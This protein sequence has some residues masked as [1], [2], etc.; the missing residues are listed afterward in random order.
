[1]E[2][3]DSQKDPGLRRRKE[4]HTPPSDGTQ[5]SSLKIHRWKIILGVLMLGSLTLKLVVT[6][7]ILSGSQCNHTLKEPEGL[8]K[9]QTSKISTFVEEKVPERGLCTPF[10][11]FSY[12]NVILDRDSASSGLIIYPD[13]KSVKLDSLPQN[14]PRFQDIY[15]ARA[16]VRGHEGF[17]SG[18]HWW[19]VWVMAG[20][21]WSLGLVRESVYSSN[22]VPDLNCMPWLIGNCVGDCPYPSLFHPA[23]KV[24]NIKVFLDYAKGLVVFYVDNNL[25]TTVLTTSFSDEKIYPVFC[26]GVG[27]HLQ[28]SYAGQ[29]FYWLGTIY[30]VPWYEPTGFSP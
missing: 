25:F 2:G 9:N 8:W 4:L 16:C 23:F 5:A 10:Q 29:P 28:L 26:L 27:T 12:A 17:T 22:F 3:R 15:H 30:T 21:V 18:Q 11:T 7:I 6:V 14:I 19:E 1:M 24:G 20:E 13:Q